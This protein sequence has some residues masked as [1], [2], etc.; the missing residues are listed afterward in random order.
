MQTHRANGTLGSHRPSSSGGA[1]G[2]PVCSQQPL[3]EGL[4]LCVRATPGKGQSPKPVCST[5]C[6]EQ[7]QLDAEYT[8]LFHLL[9]PV[10]SAREAQ[11]HLGEF[12]GMLC[13]QV[14]EARQLPLLPRD[15]GPAWGGE[16][17]THCPHTQH[18][19]LSC[20]LGYFS[21]K[22]KFLVHVPTRTVEGNK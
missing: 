12:L 4:R 7:A 3:R 8:G 5:G 19:A 9:G 2:A 13:K 16:G 6:W 10:P 11:L 1:L 20:H 15:V 22:W 14:A 21:L 18:A 17:G